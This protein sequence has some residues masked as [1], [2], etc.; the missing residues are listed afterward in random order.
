MGKIALVFQGN[1]SFVVILTEIIYIF[2]I[3]S[4]WKIEKAS[5]STLIFETCTLVSEFL[6]FVSSSS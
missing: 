6:A 3:G 2:G 5:I 1:V 4:E